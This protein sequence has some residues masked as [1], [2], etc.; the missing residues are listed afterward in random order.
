M[1]FDLSEMY[2]LQIMA[3]GGAVVV[4][5]PLAHEVMGSILRNGEFSSSWVAK[6]NI[7]TFTLGGVRPIHSR[8]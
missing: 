2:I 7:S 8:P 1:N 4:L 6:R 3:P 5:V